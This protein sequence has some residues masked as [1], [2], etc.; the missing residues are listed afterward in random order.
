MK[1]FLRIIKYD[2]PLH[3][4]LIITNWLPDNVFFIRFRGRLVSFF[5]KKSGKRLGIGRN[6]TLYNPSEIQIG[7]DVYIAYGCHLSG[8]ILIEDEVMFGP[9]CVVAPGNHLRDD[10]KSFRHGRSTESKIIIKYGAWL[11]AQS[12]I[13]GDNTV[14]GSGSVLAANSTLAKTAESDSVYGGIPAKKIK[15]LNE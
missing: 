13:I 1:K 7:N 9:Y 15:S 8:K 6:V 10:N 12:S 11:G 3:I 4:V 14:L 5:L 2:L